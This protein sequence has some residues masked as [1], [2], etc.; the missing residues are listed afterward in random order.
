MKGEV[1]ARIKSTIDHFHE[2][3]Y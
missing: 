3:L 2:L 1:N